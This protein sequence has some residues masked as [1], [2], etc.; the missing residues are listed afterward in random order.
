MSRTSRIV[1][2]GFLAVTALALAVIGGIAIS[3]GDTFLAVWNTFA[4]LVCAFI[5][6][7]ALRYHGKHEQE[8]L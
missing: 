7:D 1:F 3:V 8:F 4:I 5:V 2:A 6:A